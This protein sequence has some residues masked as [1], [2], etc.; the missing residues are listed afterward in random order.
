MS[1]YAI[2]GGVIVVGAIIVG[3]TYLASRSQAAREVRSTQD[4]ALLERPVIMAE[5]K[6]HLAE[7]QAVHDSEV[8]RVVSSQLALTPNIHLVEID[9]GYCDAVRFYAYAITTMQGSFQ[10]GAYGKVLGYT[11]GTGTDICAPKTWTTI[12]VTE[13]GDGWFEGQFAVFIS[14]PTSGAQ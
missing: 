5:M 6:R 4:T 2:V 7:W 11:T 1:L 13:L 14:T 10:T 8:H 9:Y 12:P 3:I